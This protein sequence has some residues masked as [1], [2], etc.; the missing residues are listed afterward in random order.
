[1]I[2]YIII[3]DYLILENINGSYR[4]IHDHK[5]FTY[6]GSTTGLGQKAISFVSEMLHLL[7][8]TESLCHS[9]QRKRK[10]IAALRRW[11]CQPA[12]T[13]APAVDRTG[14]NCM[15]LGGPGTWGDRGLIPYF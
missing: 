8:D 13:G 10:G 6:F 9:V 7:I 5:M 15:Y 3:Y 2:I 4:I 14:H 1:M 12:L 11:L